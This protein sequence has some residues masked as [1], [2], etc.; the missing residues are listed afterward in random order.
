MWKAAF[1]N[2][3]N[4]ISIRLPLGKDHPVLQKALDLLT[5]SGVNII[6]KSN[7]HQKFAI[8]DQKIVWYGSINLLSYGRAQESIM[9]IEGS[10]IAN[11]LIKSIEN[12]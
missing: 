9:R 4:K 8:M 10:N 3:P 1:S 5:R 11:E 2:R 12:E 7:I 6:Y